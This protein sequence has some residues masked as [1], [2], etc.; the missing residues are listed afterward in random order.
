MTSR[1][2]IDIPRKVL[3]IG[4]KNETGIISVRKQMVIFIVIFDPEYLK[5]DSLSEDLSLTEAQQ[6]G[7]FVTA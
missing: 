6:C 4:V 7:L 2:I 3:H 1:V 5:S